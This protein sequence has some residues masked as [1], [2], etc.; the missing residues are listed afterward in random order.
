MSNVV[1]TRYGAGR[2]LALQSYCMAT[3][4]TPCFSLSHTGRGGGARGSQMTWQEGQRDA[5]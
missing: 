4:A 1:C 3:P 2:T 5:P